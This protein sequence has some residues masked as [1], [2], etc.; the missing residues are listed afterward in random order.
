MVDETQTPDEPDKKPE[1]DEEELKK[2]A[3]ELEPEQ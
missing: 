1:E 3:E 2:K